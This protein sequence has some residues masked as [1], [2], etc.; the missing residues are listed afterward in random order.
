[1][2]TLLMALTLVFSMQL[3]ASETTLLC[4]DQ[5]SH[6][7]YRLQINED[8]TSVKLLTVIGDST[9][10]SVGSKN[11]KIQE[12]ESTDEAT[13]YAGKTNSALNLALLFNS[14]KA[15]SLELNQVLEVAVYFQQEKGDILSGNTHLLCSKTK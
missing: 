5:N 6:A 11:L 9:S 13:T 8:L 1:M 14:K 12:G 7:V 2:K 10:L 4:N 15:V 3:F